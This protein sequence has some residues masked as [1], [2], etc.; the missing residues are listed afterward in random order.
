MLG[1]FANDHNFALALDDLA[2]LAHGLNGRSYFHNVLP[3]VSLLALLGGFASPGDPTP[4]QIIRGN[5]DRNFVTRQDT[6]EIH[7]QLPGNMSQNNVVVSDIDAERGV[8]QGLNN[9][10]LQL[11]HVALSQASYLLGFTEP[12]SGRPQGPS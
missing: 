4:C 2:L 1:V 9:S 5:L 7:P 12:Y 3:P 11:N 8:G 6:D 10:A